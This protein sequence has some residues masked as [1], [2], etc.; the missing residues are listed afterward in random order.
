M[1]HIA[2]RTTQPRLIIFT[3]PSGAGKTTIVHRLLALDKRL[4]FSVSATTRKK[5]EKE[6]EGRHYYFLPEAEFRDKVKKGEFIEWEEVYPGI[7]YGT[8]I[9]EVEK[10]TNEG[11]AIVFDIDVKGALHIKQRYG[12]RALTI[13]VRPPS[14][15][16]LRERL[17]KR[18]SE[19]DESLTKRLEKAEYELSFESR[20]DKVLV[21]DDLEKAVDEARQIIGRFLDLP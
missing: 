13:F 14:V 6:T 9:S 3:A 11:K 1:T 2:H 19:N 8:L 16:T 15:D 20:F 18:N 10:L 21:N 4:A 12:W 7:F 5:R 17:R